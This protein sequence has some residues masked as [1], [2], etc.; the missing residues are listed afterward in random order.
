MKIVNCDRTIYVR[1]LNIAI[2]CASHSFVCWFFFFFVFF[3]FFISQFFLHCT[4]GKKRFVSP[5]L[6]ANGRILY[7]RSTKRPRKRKKAIS[8]GLYKNRLNHNRQL[9]RFLLDLFFLFSPFFFFSHFYT[10]STTFL[11]ALYIYTIGFVRRILCKKYAPTLR[12]E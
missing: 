8:L 4:S 10:F 11:W 9:S 7:G 3:F 6:R 12:E 1:T 5:S 2:V